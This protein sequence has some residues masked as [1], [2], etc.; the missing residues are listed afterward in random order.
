MAIITDPL[1]S[2]GYDYMLKRDRREAL[3]RKIDYIVESPLYRYR[4]N[5]DRAAEEIRTGKIYLS[6]TNKQN[7]PFDSSY[8]LTDEA[9]LLEKHSVDLLIRC[10]AFIFKN[11]EVNELFRIWLEATGI[12]LSE[13]IPV[14]AFA[15]Q[16]SKAINRPEGHII[17]YLKQSM[18]VGNRRHEEQYRIACFSETNASIPMWAYYANDHKGVCLEYDLSRLRVEDEY[19]NE[20]RQAFCKVHYSEYR[21]RDE[22]NDSSLIVKSSQ[23]A[24][25]HEWRLIC[26]VKSNYITVPCLSSV[27]LGINFDYDN[28]ENIIAAIKSRGTGINLFACTPDQEQYRI[29]YVKIII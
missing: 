14:S 19:E 10:I 26:D 4:P 18:D 24:H 9:L 16:F 15:K 23:W 25:E 13:S 2:V 11:K 6:E 3:F 7:D 29:K 28:I 1:H 21:P 22:H 17:L 20:L 8:G 12:P 27:Y 5:I